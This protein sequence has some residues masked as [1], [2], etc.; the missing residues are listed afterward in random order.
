MEKSEKVFYVFTICMIL[1]LTVGLFVCWRQF[2]GEWTPEDAELASMA[3]DLMETGEISREPVTEPTVRATEPTEESEPETEPA[4]MVELVGVGLFPKESKTEPE[5]ETTLQIEDAG[6]TWIAND[7]TEPTETVAPFSEADGVLLQ[8]IAWAEA[9]GEGP[10][11]MAHV[12][13]CIIN[14]VNSPRFPSNVADVIMQPGQFTPVQNGSFAAA[15]PNAQTAEALR[16]VYAGEIPNYGAT[17]FATVNS[18]WHKNNLQYLYNV[19][20]IYF[21]TTY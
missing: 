10:E 9:G 13:Q 18:A 2:R 1:F 17:Y 12:I 3:E 20:P 14:R 11:A 7:E 5:T 15:T 21:Y 19:G 8:R 16:M 4:P 6:G